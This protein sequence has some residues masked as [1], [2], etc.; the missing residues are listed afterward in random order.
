LLVAQSTI[1]M[2]SATTNRDPAML[3][4]FEKSSQVPVILCS[5]VR[6]EADKEGTRAGGRE[7]GAR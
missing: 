3:L 4:D 7:A 6:G 5:S 2:A 1:L